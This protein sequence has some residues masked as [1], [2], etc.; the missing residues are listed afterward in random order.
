MSNL[1]DEVNKRYAL[2]INCPKVFERDDFMKWLNHAIDSNGKV[3]TWHDSG[4]PTDYSDVFVLV[5][6]NYEGTESDMPEDI[7]N[8]ICDEVYKVFPDVMTGKHKQHACVQLVN[9]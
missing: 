9:I 7:W 1:F 2:V 4:E 5:D 6:A 3:A 8:A